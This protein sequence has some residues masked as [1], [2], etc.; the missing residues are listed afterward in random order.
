MLFATTRARNERKSRWRGAAMLGILCLEDAVLNVPRVRS[1]SGTT[2]QSMPMKRLALLF[3]AASVLAACNMPRGPTSSAPDPASPG[4]TRQPDVTAVVP[5]GSMPPATP[6]AQQQAL[7]IAQAAVELLETGHEDQARAELNRALALDPHS[8]LAHNLLRQ[9]TA[10]P[11]AT[12]GRESFTYTVRPTDTLS[13]IAGRFM[14]DI[15]AFYILARYNDIRVPKQVSGG[16][17]IRIPGKAPPPGTL[18]REARRPEPAVLAS[19]APTAA[20]PAAPPLVAPAPP[21]PPEPTPGE[22]AIRSAEAAKRA[23]DLERAMAEYR[24][25]AT[26]EQPGAAANAEQMRKL[27]VSRYS[28]NARSAFAKQ[29]LDGAIRYWEHVLEID[30]SNDTA[31]LERQKSL[32]LRE[33]VK[34]L[35]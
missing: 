16:Q 6:A 29:D 21:P 17:V 30:P 20:V 19:N 23:G 15:Y 25:A 14:G 9:I 13:R 3:A 1:P 28:V 2:L 34:S 18:E 7:R 24:R 27:L 32:A 5:A 8:K 31:R 35:K 11:I 4:A 10:D 26:L 33:K 22:R 12:L